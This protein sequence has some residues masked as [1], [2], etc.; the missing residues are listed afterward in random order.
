MYQLI[1]C[2]NDNAKKTFAANVSQKDADFLTECLCKIGWQRFL[3]SIYDDKVTAKNH[4]G[5]GYFHTKNELLKWLYENVFQYC[6]K[7]LDSFKN[8]YQETLKTF[9]Q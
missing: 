2:T 1:F 7:S 5:Y 6:F 3:V 8:W 9:Q 4:E